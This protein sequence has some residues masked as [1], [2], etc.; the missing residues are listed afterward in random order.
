MFI[1]EPEL[2]ISQFLIVISV[3]NMQTIRFA[4]VRYLNQH[5]TSYDICLKTIGQSFQYQKT[6]SNCSDFTLFDDQK[7][8]L[9]NGHNGLRDRLARRREIADMSRL[10]ILTPILIIRQFYWNERNIRINVFV[11]VLGRST[12]RNGWEMVETV[13]KVGEGSVRQHAANTKW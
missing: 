6:G 8:I 11:I 1:H 9:L 7:D 10:V 5:I 3:V 13:Q 12:H 4:W 2:T